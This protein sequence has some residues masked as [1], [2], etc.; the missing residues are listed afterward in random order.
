MGAKL[1][2]FLLLGVMY[3]LGTVSGV[4]WQT[5]HSQRVPPLHSLFAKRHLQQLKRELKLTPE[6]EQALNDIFDKAHERA[7]EIN[8]EVAWDLADIHEDSLKAIRDV[9]TPEQNTR[10]EKIHARSHRL[11]T[12]KTAD[13]PVE[14]PAPTVVG[15]AN[16]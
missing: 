2:A 1:K 9:L 16:S 7:K 14:I 12:E 10:F 11:S 8:E 4:A 3:G 6:Q 15:D 13:A 5:Y